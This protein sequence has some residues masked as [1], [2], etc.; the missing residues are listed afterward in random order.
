MKKLFTLFATA[1]VAMSASAET[2]TFTAPG[3]WLT[4]AAGE[5]T[6]TKDGI[7]ISTTQGWA[8]NDH[9]RVY[10]SQTFTVTSTVGNIL[11]AEIVCT[12]NGTAKYGPGNFTDPTTGTYTFEAEGPNGTWTGDAASFSLTASSN[13]VRFTTITITYGSD[14]G[15]TGGDDGG[16]T[17]GGDGNDPS[18][19]TL[20]DVN[21]ISNLIACYDNG[22]AKDND[23]VKVEGYISN[24]FLKPTSFTRYGSVCIWLAENEGSEAQE[25]ELYN[26]YGINADTLATYVPADGSEVDPTI[27]TNI[28]VSSVTDRNGVTYT[29][30]AKVVAEGK[31]KKYNTTYELNTGC[32]IVSISNST[33]IEGIKSEAIKSGKIMKGGKLYIISNG[34]T[35]DASGVLVK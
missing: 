35:Y 26:C 4:E 30:G 20:N 19:P 17:G 2:V 27:S 25:F 6:E 18:L 12:A 14:G 3:T 11:K 32:Y 22:V 31:M 15:N 1:L 34:N 9:Y 28:N 10:K 5:Q 24:M 13:Q 23:I 16:N 8:G 33:A 29:V 21:T 7:T